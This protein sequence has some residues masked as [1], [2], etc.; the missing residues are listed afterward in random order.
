[1]G[2]AGYQP[3]TA[4]RDLTEAVPACATGACEA[5]RMFKAALLEAPLGTVIAV[6][7]A[8]PDDWLAHY[9]Q[10]LDDYG[11]AA[12]RPR[13]EYAPLVT[14]AEASGGFGSGWAD[15]SRQKTPP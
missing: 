13:D 15:S 2:R 1:M 11:V 14:I 3:D 6:R 10:V 9:E 4:R 7:F 8:L 5:R 12:G